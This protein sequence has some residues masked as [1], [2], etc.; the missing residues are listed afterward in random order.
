MESTAR[1]GLQLL[2]VGQAQKE[3]THNEALQALEI[4]TAASVEEAPR[5]APPAAP[6]LGACYI[7]DS[8]AAGAWLGRDHSLACY[9]GGGWRFVD[10]VPGVAAYVKGDGVWAMYVAGSWELGKVRGSSVIV[11]GQQVVGSRAS[12]ISQPSGGSTID[13]EARATIGQILTA[14]RMHGLIET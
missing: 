1:F 12:A 8:P 3:T 9:T 10:P 5:T 2:A 6:A 7:V 11:D 13:S 4:V 14:L